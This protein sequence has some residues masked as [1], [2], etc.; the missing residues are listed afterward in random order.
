MLYFNTEEESNLINDLNDWINEHDPILDH[1]EDEEYDE[2]QQD[3]SWTWE[4]ARRHLLRGNFVEA[5]DTLET[6]LLELDETDSIAVKKI[7][8][9][10]QKYDTL[11]QQKQHDHVYAEKWT[12]WHEACEAELQKF[13]RVRDE[14]FKEIDD[15]ICMIY[16]ILAGVE[17][18]IFVSGTYFERVLGSILYA[19]PAITMS[20]L[21]HLAQHAIYNDKSVDECAYILMGCFDDAFEAQHD[22]WLQTHLGHALIAV[23]AKI[24]NCLDNVKMSEDQEAIIDPVYYCID[25][26][27]TEIA[28]K[29]SM[30]TEAVVYI[31]TC[32]E[33]REIWTKKVR[34]FY[35]NILSV[36]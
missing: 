25:A 31:S 5:V 8:Q 9:L 21:H 32:V 27:A 11:Q 4:T 19:R 34:L 24:S 30:W 10:V 22:L 7:I 20:G 18:D 15:E 6:A 14:G 35:V 3:Y 28:E 26:Y 23:G 33:N 2:G 12:D 1:T 13:M 16:S 36:G 29:Y 17:Q